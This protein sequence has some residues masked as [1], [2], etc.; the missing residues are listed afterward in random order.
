MITFLTILIVFLKTV[1]VV[2]VFAI[3]LIAV[4]MMIF[5]A[6][7]PNSVKTPTSKGRHTPKYVAEEK[8]KQLQRKE[9]EA[10]AAGTFFDTASWGFN[11]SGEMFYRGAKV[12][13]ENDLNFYKIMDELADNEIFVNTKDI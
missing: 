9:E 6:H 5:T 10:A 11:T 2:A 1:E 12:S 3:V 7:K 8:A 4:D 13:P